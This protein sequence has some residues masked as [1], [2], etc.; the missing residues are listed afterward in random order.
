[1]QGEK[2]RFVLDLGWA[3]HANPAVREGAGAGWIM[4]PADPVEFLS[5]ASEPEKLAS[6]PIPIHDSASIVKWRLGDS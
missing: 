3:S 1:M 4:R 2:T 6:T 5:P